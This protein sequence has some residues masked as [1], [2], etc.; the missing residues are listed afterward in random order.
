MIVVDEYLRTRTR[1]KWTDTAKRPLE[2]Q[3]NEIIAG[4]ITIAGINKHRR[5][6][7]EREE[8]RRKVAQ[9]LRDARAA[10]QRRLTE[11]SSSLVTNSQRWK[12]SQV[13]A[14]FITACESKLISQHGQLSPDSPES[15]WLLWAKSHA[16][17]LDPLHHDFV[18]HSVQSLNDL[19]SPV[20]PSTS[21][22]EQ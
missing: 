7:D 11:L 12:E 9:R 2:S 14:D 19:L 18:P 17:S 1:M 10:R 5:L 15:K 6:D 20:T 22:D 8:A 3:L 21:E 16:A 13:L 4:I